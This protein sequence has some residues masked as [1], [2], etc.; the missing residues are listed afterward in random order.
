MRSRPPRALSAP[1]LALRASTS[2]R[3]RSAP[4]LSTLALLALLPIA[5]APAFAQASPH[6]LTPP[7]L[8]ASHQR[9]SQNSLDSR[10]PHS[11]PALTANGAPP[12][13]PPQLVVLHNYFSPSPDGYNPE[14]QLIQASDGNLYGTAIQGGVGDYNSG[15]IYRLSPGCVYSLVYSF[16]GPTDGSHPAS[17]L[18]QASDGYLY[19][20]TSSG[21]AN[22]TGTIYQLN[23]STLAV[24]PVYSFTD[25]G[26][27]SGGD[28]IDDGQ[29]NLYGTTSSGGLNNFGSIWR[30]NYLTKTFTTLYSFTGSNDGAFPSAGLVLA[31]DGNLYGVATYGGSAS[32]ENGRGTAFFLATDGTGFTVIH[33]FHNDSTNDGA[34][35]TTDL[36]EGANGDLYGT[37]YSGGT[38]TN[39]DGVFFS[40]SPAAANSTFTALSDFIYPGDG[41]MVDLGRPFLAGDGNFYLAGSEGGAN[42][43]GQLMQVTPA[44]AVS[45]LY[46]FHNSDDNNAST[47]D[48]QP[49]E[50]ADGNL[51]GTSY[52]GGAASSGTLFRLLIGLPPA[53]TLASSSPSASLGSSVTLTWA[54]NNAFSNNAKVCF[55]SSSD[56]TDSQP[57]SFAGPM[58]IA[59]SVSVTPNSAGLIHYAIT[60][61]GVESALTSVNVLIPAI[62]T[63]T[64]SPATLLYGQSG[65][66]SVSVASQSSNPPAGTVTIA[67]NG[68][69]ILT[70]TLHNGVATGVIN[71]TPLVPGTYS[72]TAIY[73]GDANNGSS[74]S[75]PATLIVSRLTPTVSVN[76]NPGSIAEG[77][78]GSVTATV[79]NG[80]VTIPHGTVTFSAGT[81]ILGHA[82][83]AA[84]G[85]GSSATL[86]ASSAT[87]PAGSYPITATYSGD[88]DNNSAS[89]TA[90]IA[91]TRAA[92]V[93]TLSGPSHV[94]PGSTATFTISVARPNLPNVPTGS[95]TL[96]SSGLTLATANLTQGSATLHLS[97]VGVANGT[98][99]ITASYAGDTNNLPSASSPFTVTLAP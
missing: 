86:V 57:A 92:T 81:L 26:Q 19:G 25:G 98:Y 74:T 20:L 61:G 97:T 43:Y 37:T 21:G 82:T 77:A 5:A 42:G 56:A 31:S 90:T 80:G 11:A 55:A 8:P 54:A 28:P 46:D 94:T 71:S 39:S 18:V 10:V 95:I 1:L 66:I 7:P 16:T 59:G 40:I 49:F 2:R 15:A 67:A 38:A 23:L 52:Y 72:L 84:S 12:P 22:N 73:N 44:G 78:T 88:T 62:T 87:F 64:S 34:Y 32:G 27:P 75:T 24:T 29:G 89:A 85:S 36:I 60:C 93:T 63:I 41:I 48:V 9:L 45:P 33:T 50:S 68:A 3:L 4:G 96:S 83:L 35:P 58:P 14:S 13:P 79:T 69:S 53:I 91:I 17:P 6:S 99:K 76:F 30:F 65:S 51:Y 70:L 47:P